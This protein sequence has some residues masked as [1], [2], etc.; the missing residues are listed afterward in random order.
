LLV[1]A[2]LAG[3]PRDAV[4]D[5]KANT[6]I[7]LAKDFLRRGELEAAENEAEK[8]RAFDPNSAEAE[9]VLGLV[10]LMRAGANLRVVEVDDCLTG[11][12]AEAVRSETDKFL[13]EADQ[14]FARAIELDAEHAEAASNRGSVADQLGDFAA[15]IKYYDLAL[16]HPHR[17]LDVGVTRSNLGLAYFHNGDHVAAA[18]ELRQALQFKPQ[19]CLAHYRLGRV[20]FARKEWQ[21]AAEQFQLVVDD[22]TCPMQ[23][24][25]LYLLKTQRQLGATDAAARARSSCLKLTTKSCVAAQCR[26]EP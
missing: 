17:L 23:E 19:M 25:H 16:L 9:Y 14:R 26:A 2:A 11:V 7:E 15:A 20:Y 8:G 4:D 3:C 21:K 24:A 5:K 10:K 22:A 6:R 18:K 1:G 13:M 12:D